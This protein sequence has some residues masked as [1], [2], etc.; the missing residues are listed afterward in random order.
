MTGKDGHVVA[1]REYFLFDPFEQKIGISAGQIPAADAA[2]KKHIA[3][4]EQLIFVREKAKAARTVTRHFEHVHFQ[5]EKISRR[6]F[7]D[8][9]IGFDWFD[10]QLE[11]EVA[12]E[13]AIGNHRRGFGAATER[14]TEAAFDFCNV[15]DVIDVA[16]SE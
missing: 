15:L 3:A 6:D 14:A 10:L 4:D 9:E 12:K 1:E 7:F 11:A 2:G 5:T 13:F 8:E 16:V